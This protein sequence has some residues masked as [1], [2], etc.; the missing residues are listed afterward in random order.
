MK[1]NDIKKILN[2][3]T[4]IWI[5][6]GI[7]RIEFKER[8]LVEKEIDPILVKEKYNNASIT[9]VLTHSVVGYQIELIYNGYCIHKCFV[10]QLV[11]AK[12]INSFIE[13][14]ISE[15]NL[16]GVEN[17]SNLYESFIQT[18]LADGISN[19][20]REYEEIVENTRNMGRNMDILLEG[21]SFGNKKYSN[22]ETF[23][24]D[25]EIS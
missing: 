7:T 12:D 5:N 10:A 15:Y 9:S 13:G 14:S 23:S 16:I 19:K 21:R 20:I 4:S 17:I 25:T 6:K 11:K 3:A 24:N 22:T 18:L 2:I 1:I 8:M